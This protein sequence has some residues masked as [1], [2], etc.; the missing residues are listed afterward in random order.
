M[1]R[2]AGQ[3]NKITTEVRCKLENLIDG[4]INSIQ[5]EELNNTQKLKMLQ[6]ALQY[7]LPRLQ[8][9]HITNEREDLPLFIEDI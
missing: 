4:L 8:A 7:T 9:S 5:I 3:P 1:G 2:I 6:I